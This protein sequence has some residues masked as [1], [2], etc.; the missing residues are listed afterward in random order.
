MDLEYLKQFKPPTPVDRRHRHRVRPDSSRKVASHPRASVR[1]S[2]VPCAPPAPPGCTACAGEA[3]AA[4]LP[5]RA[6]CRWRS[7]S[8]S[9]AAAACSPEM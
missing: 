8:P 3:R 1:G 4:R 6:R 7:P 9:Y 5:S 2:G